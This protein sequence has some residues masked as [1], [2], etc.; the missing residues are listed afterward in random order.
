M[1]NLVNVSKSYE[2]DKDPVYIL[3]DINLKINEGEFVAIIGPSGSG[4][5]TLM[6]IIGLL[7]VPS[8]GEYFLSSHQV[9]KLEEED[10]AYLRNHYL[11]FVFQN[12]QLL[13]RATSIKNVELP[14]IYAGVPRRKRLTSAKK[15]LQL[16]ELKGKEKH[17]PNQLS[18]GQKQRVAIAR[19]LINN[20]SIILA[21]EPTGALDTK[22]SKLIMNQLEKI[23]K[24]GT[25]VIIVTH[26]LEV[27]S[28]ADR[29]IEVKDGEIKK[30]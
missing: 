14:L 13:P 10:L 19:A 12:F 26:D 16:V 24:S 21:D 15:S 22:T 29:I 1:I 20:P 8:G 4:K 25:T 9:S 18:G 6:N 7:D 30:G 28:Y 5:T 27:A 11:G 17:L 3:K 2:I 23:N